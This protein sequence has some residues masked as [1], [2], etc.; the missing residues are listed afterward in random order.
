M[1]ACPS[2]EGPPRWLVQDI[3]RSQLELGLLSPT[4][5]THD[6]A[7][8][9]EVVA[10]ADGVGGVAMASPV[11]V[12]ETDVVQGSEA[13][14]AAPPIM[15][16]L[17]A[18]PADGYD[19]GGT[20]A[21]AAARSPGTTPVNGGGVAIPNPGVAPIANGNPEGV[22]VSV[23]T[24]NGVSAQQSV[25]PVQSSGKGFAAP[26]SFVVDADVV[27]GSSMPEAEDEQGRS[28]AVLEEVDGVAGLRGEDA[29]EAEEEQSFLDIFDEVELEVC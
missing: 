25:V 9:Q 1:Y 26:G 17:P 24:S 29:M 3:T 23:D 4:L 15:G 20:A 10:G 5:A 11:P 12:T 19:A 14:P 22:I 7:C 21:A 28:T 27:A 16:R 13:L 18:T 6:V 8:K 2:T